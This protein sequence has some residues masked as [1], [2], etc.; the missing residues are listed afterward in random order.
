MLLEKSRPSLG[1]AADAC[2]S[3]TQKQGGRGFTRSMRPAWVTQR[4]SG[5]RISRRVNL[6]AGE[7]HIKL[8]IILCDFK[9]AEGTRDG[10]WEGGASQIRPK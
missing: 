4:V 5:H 9:S 2:N 7:L 8:V 10:G 6:I 1:M 3:R